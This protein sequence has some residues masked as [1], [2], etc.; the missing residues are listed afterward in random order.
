MKINI[1]DL[2]LK[3]KILTLVTSISLVI[4][5]LYSVLFYG[6]DLAEFKKNKANSTVTLLKVISEA[7]AANLIFPFKGSED[8][9]LFLSYSQVDK[10]I[11]QIV[12]YDSL[13][14]KFAEYLAENEIFNNKYS[15]IDL[16]TTFFTKEKIIA[17]QKIIYD[18]TYYG[19]IVLEA[20]IGAEYEE[21]NERFNLF[22]IIFSSI[23]VF[24]AFILIYQLRKFIS[25]PLNDLNAIMKR[26]TKE[27]D[28]TVF[29]T[30]RNNDE[31][32]EL[33]DRFND[34]LSAID[35]QS[36]AEKNAKEQA[37]HS[38]KIKEQF[39][40]NMSHEIRTPMNAIIGMTDL[41]QDTKLDDAQFT[42]LDNMRVAADNLLVIIND[43]LD[44]SKIEAGR[45]EL[46]KLEFDLYQLLNRFKSMLMQSATKK[47][48]AFEIEINENVPKMVI[49]DQVRLNQIIM[50][51]GTN[52]IK[53]TEYGG[54]LVKVTKVSESNNNVRLRFD[55][56][57]TGIGI[58]E[59]KLESIFT[60]FSQ[61]SSN[62]T[63]KYGGTGLGL[64]ISKQLV[65]LQGGKIWVKSELSKGSVFSFEIVFSKS[66]QKTQTDQVKV[67]KESSIEVIRKQIKYPLRILM[68]E[69]N[70]INQ[71]FATTVLRKNGLEVDVAEN[72]KIA[73]KK[74]Q[75]N[76]YDIIL[77]DLHMPEM[78][79]YTA[80]EYI[81]REF[82]SPKKDLPIIALTAAATTGEAEK[83]YAAGMNDYI[84]KPYKPEDLL[85][86]IVALVKNN[87][88][89]IK[90]EEKMLKNVRIT[91]LEYLT[92][93]ASGNSEVIVEMINLFLEQVP[94][95]IANM[96]NALREKNYSV[97]ASVAH[98]AKSS[99]H[100]MGMAETANE[101]SSLEILAKKSES[102]HLYPKKVQYF[103]AAC[104]KAVYELKDELRKLGAL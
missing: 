27:K 37:Q 9:E 55:V 50:N 60:S 8:A 71:L 92:N 4:L 23:F 38:L 17:V 52:A 57:D 87:N 88:V 89:D 86:K 67:T 45:I 98:K 63:R 47:G 33:C 31:I 29:I 5:L 53:F 54:V 73:I 90:V 61:A 84:S 46:E 7:N 58:P 62:T 12:I 65:E 75:A 100:I 18:N 95:F 1:K 30:K 35:K 103:I 43:I 104:E 13:N 24:F 42:Y 64:T 77:M 22:L 2:P 6:Y 20:S 99:I 97:L 28:Y 34:M 19:K 66:E 69:D 81:R 78:D 15:N 49:G 11:N 102:P 93:M 10:Y 21:R 44:F 59:D 68:A 26:I 83:C 3:Y 85:V 48:L 39:L 74:L 79:G 76:D 72:G 94:E 56:I 14:N 82:D 16:D 40:A 91:D 96:Q 101:L 36:K 25:V 80:S 70:K 51:L 41:L 32:G